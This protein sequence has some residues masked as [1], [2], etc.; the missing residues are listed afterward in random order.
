MGRGSKSDVSLCVK[1][2]L[3]FCNFIFF[4]ASICVVAIGVYAHLE[5][6]KYLPESGVDT[7]DLDIYDLLFDITI[8]FIVFGGVLFV[9]SFFGCIGSLRE[10]VCMLWTFAILLGIVFLFG[11]V[12]AVL[13]FLF[14]DD[15]EKRAEKELKTEGIKRYRDDPD[16]YDFVNWVQ[17]T[18]ECCGVTSDS[19][20]DWSMN[21]YFNCSEENISPDA[22]G[23]PYSCCKEQD[24]I[25]KGVTN[26]ECGYG[27]Q[28]KSTSEA[29]EIVYT[30]GCIEAFQDIVEQNLYIV[31]GVWLGIAVLQLFGI[32]L[33]KLLADQVQ[34]TKE[35]ANYGNRYR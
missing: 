5:K 14:K 23:V 18:F 8:I 9:I 26:T 31:G 4:L 12:G 15:F 21:I 13:A 33:A 7:H 20:K 17:E 34:T 16:W 1:Y 3:F 22:C 6:E 29:S 32:M 30:V 19:Y 2:L 24:D 10:N 27:V 25:T 35:M 28:E 11:V